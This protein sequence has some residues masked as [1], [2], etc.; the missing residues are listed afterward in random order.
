MPLAGRVLIGVGLI[1]L[2]A[3]LLPGFLLFPL[4][5]AALFFAL[6]AGGPWRGRGW[7]GGRRSYYWR[8]RHGYYGQPCRGGCG[9]RA[10]R[11][12]E[13]HDEE[14]AGSPRANTGETTRL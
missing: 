11:S 6:F 9:S 1:L 7:G 12:P 14:R 2:L 10:E 8:G 5:F 4:V 13:L 3:K